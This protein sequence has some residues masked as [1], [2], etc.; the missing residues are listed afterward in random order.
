[1]SGWRVWCARWSG[2]EAALVVAWGAFAAG[3]LAVALVRSSAG[4]VLLAALCA[5]QMCDVWVGVHAEP[6]GG[7]RAGD[8]HR[9]ARR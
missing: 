4:I 5:W 2:A 6:A 7:E 8:T 3:L 9:H 1:M